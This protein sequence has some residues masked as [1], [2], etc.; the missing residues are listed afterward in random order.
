MRFF[1]LLR[2]ACLAQLDRIEQARVIGQRFI[3][4][5]PNF[6]L[7]KWIALPSGSQEVWKVSNM[8][9]ALRKAGLPD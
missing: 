7:S 8:E 2:I 9:D 1:L 3:E 5:H 4:R 6:R